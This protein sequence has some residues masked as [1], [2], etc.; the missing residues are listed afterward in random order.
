MRSVSD[1][2]VTTCAHRLLLPVILSACASAP[3]QPLH[4]ELIL[5]ITNN[6]DAAL[7]IRIVPQ[8]LEGVGVPAPEDAGAG[9]GSLRVEPQ[10][11]RTLRIPAT[12]ELWT[13]T[14]NGTPFLRSTDHE[15]VAGGWT[16]GRIVVDPEGATSELEASEALPSG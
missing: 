4:Q 15:F 6:R 12:S 9:D 1:W 13:L 8:I 10:S 5:D 7:V 14:I 2:P 3:I 16:G 11:R